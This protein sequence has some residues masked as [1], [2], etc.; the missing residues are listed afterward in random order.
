MSITQSQLK[1][2]VK[3]NKETGVFT[4]FKI[5]KVAGTHREDKYISICV[6]YKSYLA[7][8]LAWLYVYGEMPRHFIDH[9]NHD[10][11]DN[12]IINLREVTSLESSRNLSRDKRNYSGSNGVSFMSSKNKWRA[13][14]GVRGTNIHLGMFITKEHAIEARKH[15][16]KLYG[17]HANHG[18]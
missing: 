4:R 16:E 9:I 1:S 12:R 10:R 6:N 14:I 3:Y 15:A 17:F 18:S 8:R 7:H 2:I 11:S 13:R 5:N